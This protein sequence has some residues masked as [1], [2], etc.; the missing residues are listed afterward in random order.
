[1]KISRRDFM[2][3]F[4]KA[5]AAGAAVV[6]VP[7]AIE[8]EVVKDLPPPTESPFKG[9]FADV[10]HIY[11]SAI[12]M[13]VVTPNHIRTSEMMVR[14]A[15]VS[16]EVTYEHDYLRADRAVR[17]TKASH[18]IVD[19]EVYVDDKAIYGIR[20]GDRVHVTFDHV[21]YMG[22]AEM[23]AYI[24]PDHMPAI[25]ESMEVSQIANE[26]TMLTMRFREIRSSVI[27]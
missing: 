19:L 8:A 1:M 7:K 22:G 26:L 17:E 18:R 2:K 24:K 6:A 3:L 16:Q 23:P 4:G 10:Q 20:P 21:N 11:A 5:T 25:C 13:D 12:D 9:D 15:N 27:A 14:S